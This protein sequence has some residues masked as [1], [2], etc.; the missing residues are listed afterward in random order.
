MRPPLVASEPLA[1]LLS[2]L[3]GGVAM[4]AAA[5]YVYR[6]YDG[7]DSFERALVTALVCALVWAVLGVVPL[8]G[9][10]LAFVGWLAVVRWRYPGGWLDAAM[11]AVVAWA[12]AVVLLAALELI[13][14]RTL[15]AL[16]I[17]AV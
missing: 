8:L 4:Y 12:A 3:V 9:T 5:R 14:I 6:D 17:P 7:G 10:L 1:W 15:S 11:T 16:G 13:G 2:L